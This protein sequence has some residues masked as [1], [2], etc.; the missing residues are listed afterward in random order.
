LASPAPLDEAPSVVLLVPWSQP[1]ATVSAAALI[2][3]R[4]CLRFM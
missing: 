2:R 3:L 1:V 4:K